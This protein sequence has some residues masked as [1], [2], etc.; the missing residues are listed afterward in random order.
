MCIVPKPLNFLIRL[1]PD[2]IEFHVKV[3]L[4]KLTLARE[5]RSMSGIRHF[6]NRNLRID[7]GSHAILR[8]TAIN[9]IFE[10]IWAQ[11]PDNCQLCTIET[12]MKGDF[13]RKHAKKIPDIQEPSGSLAFFYIHGC[14]VSNFH[15]EQRSI[16]H[17]W[18]KEGIDESDF[19]VGK[20][21]TSTNRV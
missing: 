12:A 13:S 2:A 4:L 18:K 1:S 17:M 3:D 16:Q 7:A 14:D 15:L 19:S 11:Y 20:T 21:R 5:F 6:Y 8:E 9:V 10:E